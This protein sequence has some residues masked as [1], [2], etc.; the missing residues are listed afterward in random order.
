MIHLLIGGAGF[1]AGYLARFC[2]VQC[3][4]YRMLKR[5]DEWRKTHHD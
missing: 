2:F 5:L 4:Q 3:N 1:G